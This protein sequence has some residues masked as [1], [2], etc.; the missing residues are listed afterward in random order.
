[1]TGQNYVM[2]KKVRDKVLLEVQNVAKD[3]KLKSIETARNVWLLPD[4]WTP[5]NQ[6]LTVAMKLNRPYVVK[7][8]KSTIDTLYAELEKKQ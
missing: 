5:E 2:K 6:M 7:A 8:F 3:L 4:D 1:M